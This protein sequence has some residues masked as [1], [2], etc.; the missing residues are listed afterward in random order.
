MRNDGRWGLGEKIRTH[1]SRAGVIRA[2]E[3][4]VCAA[5]LPA[6]RG[7]TS[8]PPSFSPAGIGLFRL[9]VF[10]KTPGRKTFLLRRSSDELLLKEYRFVTLSVEWLYLAMIENPTE[11]NFFNERF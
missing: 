6:R 9:P 11:R 10:L 7:W 3:I 5:F 1:V 8:S 4:A 2:P